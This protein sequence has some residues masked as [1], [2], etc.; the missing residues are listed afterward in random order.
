MASVAGWRQVPIHEC[1]EPL[2]RVEGERLV[3]RSAYRELHYTCALKRIFLRSGAAARLQQAAQL[4]PDGYTLVLWDGWRPVELQAELYGSY[5]RQIAADTG[6]AGEEL[7]TETQRFVSQPSTDPAKPSPH[8]TGGAIDLTLGDEDG[9]PIDMGG[10]FDELSPRTAP[11]FYDGA[12]DPAGV[13]YDIRRLLLRSVMESAGFTN[14][15]E[16]WWHFDFGNQFNGIIAGCD[17][18]YGPVFL[19]C[20]S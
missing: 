12:T 19:P 3:I 17:A 9:N 20:R 5:R 1:G 14:Y 7:E 4:L 2:V 10:A 15:P 6:L 11:D 8:L 16:E 13:L 18:V